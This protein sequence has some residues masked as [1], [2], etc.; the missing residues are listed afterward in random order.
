MKDRETKV[1][2]NSQDEIIIE[3]EGHRT[4]LSRINANALWN[5][6]YQALSNPQLKDVKPQYLVEEW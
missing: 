2:K 1:Y 4:T 5:D 6:L 3:I